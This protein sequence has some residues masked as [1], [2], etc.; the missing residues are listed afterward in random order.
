MT[1]NWGKSA[2][3]SVALLSGHCWREDFEALRNLSD[4]A[5]A[6]LAILPDLREF[7]LEPF[8]VKER[9]LIATVAWFSGNDAFWPVTSFTK[10]VAAAFFEWALRKES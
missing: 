7:L 10:H 2:I 5:F 1:F 8:R 3:A 6:H 9:P 4:W